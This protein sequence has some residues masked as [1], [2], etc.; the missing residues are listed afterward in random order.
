MSNAVLRGV[1][2]L[3]ERIVI[4]WCENSD[5]ARSRERELIWELKPLLNRAMLRGPRAGEFISWPN[6]QKALE[7]AGGDKALAARTLG[8]SRATFYRRLGPRN[9]TIPSR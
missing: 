2:E 9:L 1:W 7:D 3:I 6:V 4:E 8:M 5:I